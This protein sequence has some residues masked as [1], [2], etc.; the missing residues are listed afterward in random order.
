M[1]SA[2]SWN[3]LVWV[4]NFSMKRTNYTTEAF[5][6]WLDQVI[7]TVIIIEKNGDMQQKN[8]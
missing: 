3:L 2:Y 7:F 8:Q 4:P 5:I 1:T 6:L